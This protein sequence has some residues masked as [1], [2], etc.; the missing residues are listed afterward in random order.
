MSATFFEPAERS[1]KM[2]CVIYMHGNAGNKTE[3]FQ[4]A[5]KLLKNGITLCCF[6]FTGC[7]NSEGELVTLG[8]KE[9]H[10][11][12]AVIEFLQDSKDVSEIAL[13]GRS[14]GAATSLFYMAENP[15]AVKCAILD[16]AFSSLDN[17]IHTMVGKMGIPP[18]FV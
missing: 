3:G 14:M 1:G 13:W 2:P 15:G 11:L 12:A 10:D 7:G 17:V 9:K 18:E 16:S 6:D 5:G 8:F 4:Y